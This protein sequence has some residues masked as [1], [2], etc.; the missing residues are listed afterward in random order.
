MYRVVRAH[1]GT[2]EVESELG[3]GTTFT[4]RLPLDGNGAKETALAQ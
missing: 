2:V 3:R 1:G 4:L